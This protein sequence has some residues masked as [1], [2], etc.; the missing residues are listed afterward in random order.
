MAISVKVLHTKFT[1]QASVTSK[2]G[3]K[4]LSAAEIDAYLNTAKD[5]VL[6]AFARLVNLNGFVDDQL[7]QII[8]IG[9]NIEPTGRTEEYV[10]FAKPNA[11]V[12]RTLRRS[13]GIKHKEANCGPQKAFVRITTS[14]KLDQLL[15]DNYRKPSFSARETVALRTPGGLRVY[16]GE[17]FTVETA[18]MDY[19]RDIPYVQ[20][21]SA[22]LDERYIDME[23]RA[24]T[25]NVDFELDSWHVANKIVGLA[26]MSYNAD[27]ENSKDFSIQRAK[28]LTAEQLLN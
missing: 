7:Q 6:P 9:K 24:V 10:E 2:Q 11:K 28:F 19:V 17:D 27:N 15:R 8:E 20:N 12:L 22:D 23:D 14:D 16:N 18:V 3:K 4:T 13:V 1:Q 26:V 5:W 21:P 25:E